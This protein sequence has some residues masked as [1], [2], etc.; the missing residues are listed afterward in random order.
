MTPLE[1]FIADLH[2]EARNPPTLRTRQ[3]PKP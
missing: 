3:E 2:D 1:K